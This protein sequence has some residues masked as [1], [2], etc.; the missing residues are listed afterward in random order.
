[1]LELSVETISSPLGSIDLVAQ[2]D[3]LVSVD[4]S[5]CRDRMHRLLKKR[6]GAVSLVSR[7]HEF[8]D[9]LRAYFEGHLQAVEAAPLVL[10]GTP[11]Q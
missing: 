2:S 4:F 3:A 5:D 7:L 1:M 6:F 11:F 10:Q 9:R 8:S